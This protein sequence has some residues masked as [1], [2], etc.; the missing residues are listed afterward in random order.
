MASTSNNGQA[1]TMIFW[2]SSLCSS[3]FKSGLIVGWNVRSFICVV[4]SVVSDISIAEL[5]KVLVELMR[6]S[7]DSVVEHLQ[8]TSVTPPAILGVC[9][10]SSL[11]VDDP[12]ESISMARDIAEY[13]QTANIWLTVDISLRSSIPVLSSIYCC[14]YRYS[15]LAPQYFVFDAPDPHFLQSLELTPLVLDTTVN[16]THFTNVDY[17][18]DDPVAASS[19]WSPDIRRKLALHMRYNRPARTHRDHD[20]KNIVKQLNCVH[21]LRNTLATELQ[22]YFIF[23]IKTRDLSSYL[24]AMFMSLIITVFKWPSRI[25]MIAIRV[26][27]EV[28]LVALQ[29]ELSFGPIGNRQLTFFSSVAQQLDL[30]LQQFC[31]WPW[32]YMVFTRRGWRYSTFNRAQYI[33]FFNSMWLIANDIIIGMALGAILVENNVYFAQ[34]IRDLHM[35]YTI[36]WIREAIIWLMGWPAGL[37]LNSNLDNFLGE[38]FA[39]LINIWSRMTDPMWP[40]LPLF[41]QFVG[42][43]GIF[44]ATMILSVFYD[45]FSL[46]TLHLNFFYFV[47]MRIYN[48]QLTALWSLFNLFQGKK[49]NVLRNRLD[50]SDFDLDQLLLGTILFTLLFFLFPTVIVYYVLFCMAQVSAITFKVVLQVLLAV[51][52]HFPLFALMLR[53]KDPLRLPGGIFVEPLSD[54]EFSEDS[55]VRILKSLSRSTSIHSDIPKVADTLRNRRHLAAGRHNAP[56]TL[57]EQSLS[58]DDNSTYMRL[59]S[60]SIPLAS[61]FFQYSLLS[62]RLTMHYIS[63]PVVKAILFGEP[64]ETVSNLEY[65]M[66]PEVRASISTFWAFL[67]A[68]G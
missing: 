65:P 17:Q 24:L 35:E 15:A 14:G 16:D 44:G 7:D 4:A 33:S 43:L 13:R 31:F 23:S 45:M 2:P 64:I 39:W 36:S 51:L 18:F 32:Q 46:L 60:V 8:K 30:R 11:A 20:L 9:Y 57:D 41:V 56:S 47:A 53:I 49:Y 10:Q 5:D 52:N 67:N 6:S 62:K 37:K 28:L 38:L 58:P 27:S 34:C 19:P 50:S 26:V 22:P 48:A 59:N 63:W 66:L 12:V 61:I 68:E 29:R 42:Y 55:M 25:I 54:A 3:R 21:E 40:Y 1:D